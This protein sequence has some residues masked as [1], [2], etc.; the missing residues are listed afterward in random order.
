MAYNCSVRYSFGAELIRPTFLK[1]HFHYIE[2]HIQVKIFVV[3]F[4]SLIII[5]TGEP[6]EAPPI[7]PPQPPLQQTPG[8]TQRQTDRPAEKR[9]RQ[10]Q[11]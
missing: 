8:S 4:N 10:H 2:Q 9:Y 1:P 6:G 5:L 7:Y 11:G 3:V